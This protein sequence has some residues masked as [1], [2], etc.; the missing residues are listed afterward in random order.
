MGRRTPRGVPRRS[1]LFLGVTPV[2]GWLPVLRIRHLPDGPATALRLTQSSPAPD[3]FLGG[4]AC[5]HCRTVRR[6]RETVVLRHAD[7]RLVQVG[8]SC[9]RVF[10][11]RPDAVDELRRGERDAVART[12]TAQVVD[13]VGETPPPDPYVPTALYLAHVCAVARRDGFVSAAAASPERPATAE[14]ALAALVAAGATPSDRDFTR[15]RATMVWARERLGLKPTLTR[16]ER[17]VIATL[18]EDRLTTRE[19][20]TAAAAV[21]AF[22]RAG[23]RARAERRLRP[24]I[25]R[26]GESVE[27]AVRVVAAVDAGRAQGGRRT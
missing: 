20:A 27:V 26:P 9:L 10:T 2:D 24:H 3:R 11:G 21:P 17:R 7:G 25:G 15:A 16:F 1:A 18:A 14:L 23:A 5:E 13:S 22:V 12:P 19:L 6:R 8:T 4:P